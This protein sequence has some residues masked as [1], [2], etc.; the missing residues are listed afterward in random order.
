MKMTV[1]NIKEMKP[2][3]EEELSREAIVA[4][5]YNEKLEAF[6]NTPIDKTTG[7]RVPHEGM[8]SF[9]KLIAEQLRKEKE[10]K[11][12]MSSIKRGRT[13]VGSK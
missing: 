9:K 13:A 8:P 11:E 5:L 10:L 6:E 3:T 7:K 2:W 1:Q 12:R 4:K